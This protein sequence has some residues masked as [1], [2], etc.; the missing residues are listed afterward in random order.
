MAL[1]ST[2]RVEFTLAHL[3]TEGFRGV[4]KKLE[5]TSAWM[6]HVYSSNSD[7]ALAVIQDWMTWNLN[8]S[9]IEDI[10]SRLRDTELLLDEVARQAED[11]S[12]LRAEQDFEQRYFS[13]YAV[14]NDQ[15]Q[16][17]YEMWRNEY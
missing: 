13:D 14:R 4:F 11:V 2:D 8:Q 12:P 5:D 3:R 7:E 9:V 15:Y 10:E 6:D 16:E 17:R 1:S